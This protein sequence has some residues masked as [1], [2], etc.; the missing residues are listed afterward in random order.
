[1]DE[2]GDP[3]ETRSGVGEGMRRDVEGS[4][5]LTD[6]MQHCLFSNMHGNQTRIYQRKVW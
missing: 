4:N 5:Y 1:L 2:D 3:V 6:Y